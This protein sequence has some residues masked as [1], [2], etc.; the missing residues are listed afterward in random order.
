MEDLGPLLSYPTWVTDGAR[1]ALS[2][3]I[4]GSAPNHPFWVQV[5]EA[6]P[7]YG[8]N[9]VFPYV[10]ISY[11]SG[12]WFLTAVWEEY[13]RLLPSATFEAKRHDGKG[14]LLRVM[15]DNRG[16]NGTWVEQ[17]VFFSQGRGMSWVGWDNVLF[18]WI[19]DHVFLTVLAGVVFLASVLWAA[20]RLGQGARIRRVGYRKLSWKD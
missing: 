2:N 11:A 17:W 3:N 6:L 7:Q 1:G 8:W 5:T 15:M 19:G 4:L 20:L 14:P 9:Y 18:L 13:H 12:Q 16:A 10:T